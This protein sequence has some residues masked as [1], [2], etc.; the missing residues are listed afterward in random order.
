VATSVG[1]TGMIC[2]VAPAVLFAMGLMSGI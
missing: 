1:L 2:C